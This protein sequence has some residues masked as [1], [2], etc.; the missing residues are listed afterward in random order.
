MQTVSMFGNNS[1][2]TLTVDNT[3]VIEDAGG[4]TIIKSLQG[5]CN[6]GS[7]FIAF[8]IGIT[9]GEK[10]WI[11]YSFPNKANI[12]FLTSKDGKFH[13]MKCEEEILDPISHGWHLQ[14]K[15][16][17]DLL[18]DLNHNG[19]TTFEIDKY[20]TVQYGK[21]APSIQFFSNLGGIFARG[22]CSC[23]K[24]YIVFHPDKKAF[25]EKYK[26]IFNPDDINKPDIFIAEG[27]E[28][29]CSKCGKR[30]DLPPAENLTADKQPLGRELLDLLWELEVRVDQIIAERQD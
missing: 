22:Q 29:H 19:F 15:T 8:P 21:G 24:D 17:N 28:D 25:A 23:G 18:N 11:E 30:A 10:F 20:L 7:S 13:C 26:M 3:F 2:L 14:G 27:N 6:C 16:T 9:N 4:I 1:N 12:D 5:N